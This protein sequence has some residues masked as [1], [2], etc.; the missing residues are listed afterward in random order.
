M[1][2]FVSPCIILVFS[3]VQSGLFSSG[4]AIEIVCV[5][6]I[7]FHVLPVFGVSVPLTYHPRFNLRKNISFEN[8]SPPI[9][10]LGSFDVLLQPFM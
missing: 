7:T 4:Y 8:L 1:D 6:N 2:I 9:S 5:Y 10:R 3:S